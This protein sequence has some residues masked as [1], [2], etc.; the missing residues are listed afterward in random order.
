MKN[1][2]VI[3][4]AIFLCIALNSSGAHAY[5][6]CLPEDASQSEFWGETTDPSL[7]EACPMSESETQLLHKELMELHLMIMRHTDE[8]EYMT[9][10]LAFY[11]GAKLLNNRWPEDQ[12]RG[13]QYMQHSVDLAHGLGMTYEEYIEVVGLEK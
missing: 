2:Y 5:L 1:K 8:V 11:I 6:L 4:V 3:L 10:A 9:M 12:I 13:K 7:Y